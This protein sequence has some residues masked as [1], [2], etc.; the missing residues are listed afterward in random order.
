MQNEISALGR[1]TRRLPDVRSEDRCG[2]YLRVAEE[3]IRTFEL[4]VAEAR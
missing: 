4:R 2:R 1:A 3:P